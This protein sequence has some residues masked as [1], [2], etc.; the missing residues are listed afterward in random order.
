MRTNPISRAWRRNVTWL[1]GVATCSNAA[2]TRA[3][4]W[5]LLFY[6]HDLAV[7]DPYLQADPASFRAWA[8]IV[9]MEALRNPT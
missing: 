8:K 5:N 3:A 6:K 2:T 1:R 9:T 4:D 7:D